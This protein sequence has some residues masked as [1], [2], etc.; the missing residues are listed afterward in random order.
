MKTKHPFSTQHAGQWRWQ[1]LCLAL[2]A[3][4]LG[5]ASADKE[6][7]SPS[8]LAG[9]HEEAQV[10]R[11][12]KG[13][14]HVRAGNEH[15]L[16]FLQGYVTAEDRLFQM[17]TLRR[18]GN[19]TFAELAGEAALPTDV[20]LRT[21]GLRRAAERTLPVLAERTRVALEAYAE[22]VNA[23]VAAHPLPPEYGALE[24]T[25]FDPW[26]ALDCVT[27]A[28]LITFDRSFDL[29][30][31]PT[32][33]LGTYRQ[34]GAAL[35][36]DGA[37]L[38]F[39]DLFRSAPFDPAATVL[40]A[41]VPDAGHKMSRNDGGRDGKL[42]QAAVDL[43]R[44]YLDE[45]KDLP[46]FEGVLHREKRPASNEWGVSGRHTTSGRPLLANDPHLPLGAPSTMYPIHLRAGARNV[47]GHC[48]VGVPFVV[49]GHNQRISWGAAVNYLDVTDTFQEQV[50]PDAA[51][52]SGLSIVHQGR[53]EPIIPIPQVFR[54]NNFDGIPDN[55]TVVPPGGA[56]PPVTLVVPRRNNGPIVNLD[57]ANGIA[58]SVQFTGF[59]ATR[60]LDTFEIWN[61]AKNLDE[62]VHGLQFFDVGSLNFAYSDV[63]G[64]IAYFSGGEVPVRE[65]LQAGTIN[66]LPPMFI[67]NG[68][69]G[70]EWLPVQN[71]QPGQA[72]PYEILPFSETP[73]IINPPA[74]WF[75][76]ANNDPVGNTHDNNALNQLRPGGGIFYLNA[77][78]E[79]VRAGRITQLIRGKLA[80]GGKISVK[81]MQEI[82]ADTVLPDAAVFVPHLLQAWANAQ[83]SGE[84]A[85]AAFASQPR[86]AEAARRLRG[87]NFTTPTGIP[88]GF[89][90]SDV[91]GQRLA[92][93]AEEIA[94]S[95]AATIY[96]VWRG[97]FVRNTLDAPLAPFGLPVVDDLHALPALR[98]LLDQFPTQAGVGA[99]GLNFFNVPGVGSAADRRD[100]VILKSLADALDRLAGA[101]FAAAF[102]N[103]ANLED[104]RWGKLHRLVLN[105]TLG[106]PFNI[107]PAGGAFPPPLPGLD[108]IPVDGGLGSVDAAPH[109][110]RADDANGFV[111]SRG[112]AFRLVTRGGPGMM[113]GVSSVPGGV[114]GVLGS[115]RYAD[116]LPEW[117][118]N[119]A[120]PLWTQPSEVR[121]HASSV[122]QFI[123]K[124][125]KAP[126]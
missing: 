47:T 109:L 3:A 94:A 24:T 52:P 11:D 13:I 100:I 81:D 18:L 106:G 107:P 102:A 117:L 15:D 40:D 4:A 125:Y 62:F 73:Q 59:S 27:I 20:Q 63:K 111:S 22:G 5:S 85:L 90:A 122:E 2:I 92:P 97:Q 41:S 121:L 53:N 77:S 89:D 9:L 112:A 108:G 124:N 115:P 43:C 25:Q 50:V 80:R 91:S 116:L 1:P 67:R 88:E 83:S 34:A 26:T 61:G 10:T 70:N 39:E 36:F 123:P 17:D 114:S 55:V 103:S 68:T 78:Y 23:W 104:Y 87:W 54:K 119:E 14:A 84:P 72:L 69:G 76:N 118:T 28:K 38:Y 56:I 105:H 29:D 48:F 95:V 79:T 12:E 93:T 32:I 19:G 101:P 16:Y 110:L 30:I 120:F 64:N 37:A 44:K 74:G 65:D 113:R 35:G 57:L 71:P 86:V 42:S 96:S 60:E 58:L 126:K 98:H 6:F 49:L 33:K 51:S 82:Q 46:A 7:V 99:S 21:M 75:V 66:G 31:E 8:K 45:I